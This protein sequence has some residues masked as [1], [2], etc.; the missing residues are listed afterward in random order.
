M[1]IISEYLQRTRLLV[2]S[3]IISSFIQSQSTND[4]FSQYNITWTSQSENSSGSMPVGGGDIGC[5]VWVEDGDILFYMSR[6]G[7]FDENNG[8]M[9][10]GRMRIRIS[11]NPFETDAPFSQTL[12]LR[13][14]YVE[15]TGETGGQPAKVEIWVDVFNPVIHVNIESGKP[16]AVE[17]AYE[18]W[19]TKNREMTGRETDNNRSFVG[20]PVKA[21]VRKDSTAF[22]A[23]DILSFHRNDGDMPDAF[24]LCLEQQGLAGVKEQMWNPTKN[25]IFGCL[26]RGKNMEPAGTGQGRYAS[27]DYMAWKIRSAEPSLKHSIKIYLHIGQSE[28]LEDWLGGL[29]SLA[30]EYEKTSVDARQN[31]LR[32]W[33]DFWNRSH[34]IIKPSSAGNDSTAWSVGRNY[35]LFRYQLGCNAYGEYPTKFNGGLFTYDPEFVDDRMKYNADYRRWGGGSFTAQNQR[36]VYW[37]MLKSGDCDMMLPQFDF[38]LRPLKNAELRTKVYWGHNGAS[39]TE[40]IESFALPVAFEYGWN[41]PAG[42]DP[43]VQYNSWVEYQWDTALEF[44]FM[45]LEYERYNGNDISKYIPLIESCL[46]FFDEHYRYLSM[47]RTTKAL[48][49]NGHLVIYPGTACETY[50]M[51]TNPVSTITALNSVISRLLQISEKYLPEERQIYYKEYLKRIPP[52][53]F[54]VMNGYHTIAPADRYERI[55]NIELPQLYPVYPYGLYGIGRSDMEVAVNTWKYGY[56]KPGQKDFISWHQDAIFCARLGQTGEAK[57][58]TVKKLSDS[59][60]RFPAFWGPGHDWVPDH[61]WGGS[62]MIG[63]QEMLMQAVGEKIYL[64]PAWPKEWDVDFKLHAPYNTVVEGQLI[65]GKLTGIVVTPESRIKDIVDLS[66]ADSLSR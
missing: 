37:P 63:L 10:S 49:E 64:F 13:E 50:K 55:N 19:R 59:G 15:I 21:M 43:G 4:R 22:R 65:D 66:A 34:I 56:E 51:A 58:I 26:V 28:T 11:P 48:D 47:K 3:L 2:L 23:G 24:D 33:Q 62:G 44:C 30:D 27:A 17:A 40:Q 35:Q 32:W 8:F 5:N 42:Y 14:G 12:K 6:S 9:K 20:A 39:F 25:L 41:R 36:L 53:S 54:R 60:R 46:V 38:Y 29:Y 52:V 7:A 18:S 45:I 57:E 61:N 16:V 31:T 1:K